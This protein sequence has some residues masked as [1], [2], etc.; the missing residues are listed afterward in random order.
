MKKMKLLFVLAAICTLVGV[1]A[2]DFNIIDRNTFKANTVNGARVNNTGDARVEVTNPDYRQTLF[3][4]SFLSCQLES[5][6]LTGG[7]SD[8]LGALPTSPSVLRDS[9]AAYDVRGYS[10]LA[11]MFYPTF[12]AQH[13]AVRIALQ[14]RWH[15][16][17]V[18]DSASTFIELDHK[19][20]ASPDSVVRDS[21]GTMFHMSRYLGYVGSSSTAYSDRIASADEQVIVLTNTGTTTRGVV[22]RI[23]SPNREYAAAGPYVSIRVRYLSA[24]CVIGGTHTKTDVRG[25]EVGKPMKLTAALVGWR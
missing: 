11:V 24:T 21:I 12:H 23:G 3:V 15:P 13:A 17:P 20:A 2:A 7:V 18:V 1:A 19:V 8:S 10:N 9:T 4:P 6:A 16:Y 22:V 5:R 14:V 25:L